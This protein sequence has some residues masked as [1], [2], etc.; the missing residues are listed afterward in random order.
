MP[1]PENVAIFW[2]YGSYLPI[3]LKPIV[4]RV[5]VDLCP[6]S[7]NLNGYE[8]TN[9]IRS[10][11]HTFGSVVLFK[12]YLGISSSTKPP[13]VLLELQASGVSLTDCPRKDA[14]ATNSM[15]IGPLLLCPNG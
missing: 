1:R 7:P 4:V 15:M 12:A 5:I 8:I 11:A 3:S 6:I 13:N 14:S 2:D 9:N 10:I